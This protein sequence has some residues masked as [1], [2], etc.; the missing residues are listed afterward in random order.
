M[1]EHLELYAAVKGVPRHS[2]PLVVGDMIVSLELKGKTETRVA[3]LSG[4]MQRKLQ[5]SITCELR[6]LLRTFCFHDLSVTF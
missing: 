4:G 1:K 3:C 5:V 2:I 6:Q